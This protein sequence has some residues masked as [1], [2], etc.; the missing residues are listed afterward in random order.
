MYST[1]PRFIGRSQRYAIRAC[2]QYRIKGDRRWH[3]GTCLN[4]SESGTLFKGDAPVPPSARFDVRLALPSLPNGC[5][6]PSIYFQALLVR[7]PEDHV[8]AARLS[9]AVILRKQPERE[10]GTA[11]FSA[12]QA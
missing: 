6:A 8:W 2:L 12:V 11:R 7:S 3:E 1:N 4:V 5:E 9:G 10:R